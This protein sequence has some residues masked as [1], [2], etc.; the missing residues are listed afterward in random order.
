MANINIVSPLKTGKKMLYSHKGDKDI[1]LIDINIC[2]TCPDSVKVC[3]WIGDE[4]LFNSLQQTTTALA[5]QPY[6]AIFSNYPIEGWG[7]I[8][9]KDKI[10]KKGSGIMGMAERDNVISVSI[11][12]VEI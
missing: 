7:T 5:S 10:L 2:N 1:R 6:G 3:L 4:A 11:D 8:E 9:K 12:G